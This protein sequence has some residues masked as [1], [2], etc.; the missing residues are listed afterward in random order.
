MI[1]DVV[2]R[3]KVEKSWI[4]SNNVEQDSIVL[5]R[6]SDGKWKLLDTSFESEDEDYLYYAAQT[7]GFS[8]FAILIPGVSEAV[9]SENNSTENQSVMSTG[10]ELIPVETGITQN[11]KSYK[12][13]LLFLFVGL[14]GAVG[15][16]GY[17]YRGHYE[18]LYLQ[19]SN[20]D[21]K[22]Y[23]RLKK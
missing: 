9:S 13:I 21:G 22:R 17:R 3:F 7:P 11:K 14:I 8:P 10:D 19:I 23:R 16:V 15:F 6:Y 12:G 5:S 2:I 4:D 18:Q 20:P 1:S